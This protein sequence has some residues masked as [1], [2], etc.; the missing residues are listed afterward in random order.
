M[1]YPAINGIMKTKAGETVIMQ[2]GDMIHNNGKIE[3]IE[4]D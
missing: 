2:A 4:M 1:I 3:R